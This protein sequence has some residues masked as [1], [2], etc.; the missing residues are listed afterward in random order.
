MEGEWARALE[1]DEVVEIASTDLSDEEEESA[2]SPGGNV[3]IGPGGGAPGR[4]RPT[5]P[6]VDPNPQGPGGPTGR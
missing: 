4:K 5:G 1:P 6:V 2:S 3:P